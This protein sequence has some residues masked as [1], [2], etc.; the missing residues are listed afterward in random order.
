MRFVAIHLATFLLLR[1]AF[2]TSLSD[3]P[4]TIYIA[5]ASS[6]DAIVPVSFYAGVDF[7]A[8]ATI[9]NPELGIHW[10]DLTQNIKDVIP[11][12]DSN[13]LSFCWTPSEISSHLEDKSG[14]NGVI[15][16]S[17]M[18]FA[19]SSSPGIF[20][21]KWNHTAV[22][23][24]YRGLG[25]EAA[26]DWRKDPMACAVSDFFNVQLI[27]TTAIHAGSEIFPYFGEAWLQSKEEIANDDPE[28]MLNKHFEKAEEVMQQYASLLE[29]H[30]G[31]FIEDRAQEYW[32]LI[33]NSVISD[34]KVRR[35]LP[36]SHQK[37]SELLGQ[38]LI[39][40]QL[41]NTLLNIEYL[42]S[43][44]T[45]M[46]NLMQGAKSTI[47]GAGRG[48]FAKR[49]VEKGDTVAAVPLVRM[50]KQ[51]LKSYL[52]D[53]TTKERLNEPPEIQLVANYVL[54]HP[55]SPFVFYP[56]G[57]GV[58]LINHATHMDLTPNVK[59]VWSE[60]D[61]HDQKYLEMDIKTIEEEGVSPFVHIMDLVAT[62]DIVKGEEIL[63]DYG[64]SFDQYLRQ[65]IDAYQKSMH[66]FLLGNESAAVL[67]AKNEPYRT[68]KEQISSPY[69]S[70]VLLLCDI[71]M[72]AASLVDSR[73]LEFLKDVEPKVDFIDSSVYSYVESSNSVEKH[74][75]ILHRIKEGDNENDPKYLV[76]VLSSGDLV[77]ITDVP[78]N[79]FIFVDTPYSSPSQGTGSFRHYIGIPDD[80]FPKAW[81]VN[82]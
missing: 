34:N 11:P 66:E 37:I 82:I 60:K 2:S 29:K 17:G 75:D 51:H 24:R 43:H 38:S 68:I 77:Y 27:S 49:A 3:D 63:L 39:P 16:M 54:G 6:D 80:I 31:F 40:S 22:Y 71:D 72:E 14:E 7:A 48:A 13:I 47:P 73:T 79:A 46:D 23:N 26:L 81:V 45:C 56:Y 28:I 12:L 57:T 64:Q 36:A 62:K 21:A 9:G 1:P 44:G 74:C 19:G 52:V 53:E 25:V 70:D 58:N 4:C 69:P 76:R 15:F 20:N 10:V 41:P 61:Y 35:L 50:Y 42:K 8:N 30:K 33:L 59:F 67:N 65:F 5:K 32:D 55:K 18:G 78:H